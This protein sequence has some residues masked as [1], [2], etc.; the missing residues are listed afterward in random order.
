MSFH[1]QTPQSPSHF[2]PS[3]SDQSTSMSGSIVSTTTT[4]PTPAHS[5]NGSSLANDMSFTDIVMGENSPQKRK[6]TSDD[7]GDREQKKVHIEDRKLGIDD[8][9]LDVGEKYLLCRSRKAPFTCTQKK[10]QQQQ[11][12]G[13]QWHMR[14]KRSCSFWLMLPQRR[15]LSLE[16]QPPRPHLSEDL[17]EMYGLADLAAE[18]ARI[19]DGQKNALRKTYKGHIKKLGVQGHFDSV[20][21]DEKDP[22]RLEYLM[23]CPQEEWN[24]HFVRGKEITRGLSSDMKSKISRAVTMSRGTVP[25]TLWNNSVLGD[26]AASSMKA[27]LNQPPS[28]RPTAPNTPLAYG[29]PAM[30]RVKP[31]T[32]G[33]Q[34]NRP[35]RNIKKRGYGDSSFEGYGEGFE[36]DGGLETGYSTG[37]GDMASGLKRRKKAQPGTQSYAQAR[38]QSSYGHHGVSGI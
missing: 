4:L 27:H 32:P 30:Q 38:Q 13:R 8:L 15:A 20:K 12:R 9:H 31:Q 26:I 36:D 3:S 28:A 33:F 17:F 19:K 5:V 35:R 23:G 18:Y 2:S 22:E 34:D 7:V 21:T 11:Q 29:G 16:H 14:E 24:A 1:P 37:E 6:R 25:S 10:Q